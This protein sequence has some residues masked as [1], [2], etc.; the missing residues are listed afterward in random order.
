[1][2]RTRYI[3]P[4]FFVNDELA[5]LPPLYRIFFIGLWTQADRNGYLEY[6][7]KRLKVEILPYDEVCIETILQKLHQLKFIEVY[8]SFGQKYIHICNFTKHQHPHKDEKTKGY[9]VAPMLHDASIMQAQCQHDTNTPLNSNSN[10][11]FNSTS[12]LRENAQVRKKNKVVLKPDDV[13]E[14]VWLEWRQ[15]RKN[16]KATISERVVNGLRQE[17]VLANMTLRQVM[18]K[19]CDKGWRGF[20]AEW[21]FNE[22]GR[23]TNGK[24]SKSDAVEQTIANIERGEW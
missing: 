8:E 5:E 19:C 15:L 24:Q 1:M 22:Q 4:S 13:S 10:S 7:P 11:N 6:K 9:P 3:K 18:E 21:I 12:H 14:D 17:G 20:K 23:K 16:Q 2:A